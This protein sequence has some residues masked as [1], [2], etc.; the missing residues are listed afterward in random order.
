MFWWFVLYQISLATNFS[1]PS[2]DDRTSRTTQVIFSLAL[3]Q[4]KALEVQCTYSNFHTSVYRPSVAGPTSHSY[5]IQY[6]CLACSG[7]RH[8]FSVSSLK[9]PCSSP[10]QGPLATLLLPR[11]PHSLWILALCLLREAFQ[12]KFHSSL[13]TS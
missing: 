6:D 8:T 1:S 10:F 7:L 5:S 12:M 13:P 9:T 2:Q 11:T 3:Q 4:E